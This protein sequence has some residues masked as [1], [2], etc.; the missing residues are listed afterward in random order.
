MIDF[1][2]RVVCLICLGAVVVI[3]FF[4][5]EICYIIQFVRF[6]S[7]ISVSRDIDYFNVDSGISSGNQSNFLFNIENSM[8]EESKENFFLGVR[9]LVGVYSGIQIFVYIEGSFNVYV[10]SVFWLV[11]LCVRNVL[12]YISENGEYIEFLLVRLEFLQVLVYL[13]KGYFLIIRCRIIFFF[14]LIY[15]IN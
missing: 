15:L 11:K 7:Y 2:V 13:V 6:F 3:Q 4:L 9:I 8:I 14:I 5:M 10:Y 1:N 12:F